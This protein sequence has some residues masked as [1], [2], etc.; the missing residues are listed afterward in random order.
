[1]LVMGSATNV[2][3]GLDIFEQSAVASD[4]AIGTTSAGSLPSDLDIGT[5]RMLG[6]GGLLL[7][8]A[9][10]ATRLGF[11]DLPS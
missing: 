5:V 4:G 2:S 8:L 7:L 1:M 3:W 9:L 10:H 6:G 11:A